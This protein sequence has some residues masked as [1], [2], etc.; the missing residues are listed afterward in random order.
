[1]RARR[2][3]VV[4]TTL[5]TAATLHGGGAAGRRG[6]P[7]RAVHLRV[8]RGQRPT[9]R[10]WR[11]STARA[12]RSISPPAATRSRCTSTATRPPALTITLT[13]TV[14][15][16]DVYVVAQ[17]TANADDPRPGRPD[18]RLGLVQRR[19]RDRA[20]QGAA[21]VDRLDRPDRRRPRHRVGHRADQHRRQHAAPQA[22]RRGRRHRRRPTPSTRRPSGTASPPT[23]STGSAPTRSTAAA[24]AGRAGLR[25]DARPRRPVRPPPAR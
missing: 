4:A 25:R 21:T 18:Q 10:P 9:T 12:H 24:V 16:G 1:M 6:R 3:F 8:H 13:G 22:D 15:D 17:S 19:R 5:A 7:D 20:P 11:S 2:T 23:P 14:A